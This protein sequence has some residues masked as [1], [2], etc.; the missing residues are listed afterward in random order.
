VLID[1]DIPAEGAVDHALYFFVLPSLFAMAVLVIALQRPGEGALVKRLVLE[2]ELWTF[3]G[4][5]SLQI[6]ML[7]GVVANYLLRMA[8]EDW[9]SITPP[10]SVGAGDLSDPGRFIRSKGTSVKVRE[11]AEVRARPASLLI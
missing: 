9:P 6:Y 8:L 10:A 1:P 3:V 2:S 4:N 7:H 5:L 11:L